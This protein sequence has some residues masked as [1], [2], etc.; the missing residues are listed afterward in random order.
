MTTKKKVTIILVVIL[1]LVTI[2]IAAFFIYKKISEP[3][4]NYVESDLKSTNLVYNVGEQTGFIGNNF[5]TINNLKLYTNN[6]YPLDLNR[7][8]NMN[9]SSSDYKTNPSL[10]LARNQISDHNLVGMDIGESSNKLRIGHW[11]TLNFSLLPD[12]QY[13]NLKTWKTNNSYD[14]KAVHAYYIACLISKFKF[15]LIG[16]TE[17]N[18]STKTSDLYNFIEFLNTFQNG[19]TYKGILSE[20]LQGKTITSDAQIEK[21]AVIYNSK[22][23]RK[24]DYKPYP[25]ALYKIKGT[26]EKPI[27]EEVNLN[28]EEPID[29]K[30]HY[31]YV[32]PPFGVAFNY[33]NIQYSIAFSH[34]DSPGAKKNKE[35][36][37]PVNGQGMK[38]YFEAQQTSNVLNWLSTTLAPNSKAIYM[39]D[40]NIQK[41][42]EKR[43]F[44]SINP[45]KYS[46][47][48]KDTVHYSSSLTTVSSAININNEI[49]SLVANNA[50]DTI[51][52]KLTNIL[53]KF[54]ANPYDKIIYDN[55]IL[56]S[57]FK[58][59]NDNFN[60]TFEIDKLSINFINKFIIL[61]YPPT[62]YTYKKHLNIC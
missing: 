8:F 2:G 29:T 53:T 48:F 54:Y 27:F 17:I 15:D 38:E 50:Q 7:L 59:E 52:E 33:N 41:E 46:F 18:N 23:I 39:G 61:Y 37:S 49:N 32:R 44:D 51:S 11:N 57:K 42:N 45:N 36:K 1:I 31:D 47:A 28:N 34:N 9:I 4:N 10:Y 56:V 12:E 14:P 22:V 26:K 21:V 40:T 35:I 62:L 20:P 58:P 16:L 19:A 55:S 25:N 3:K 13:N 6:E 24:I 30:L 5:Q 60:P 43:S